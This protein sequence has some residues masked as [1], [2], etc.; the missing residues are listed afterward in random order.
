MDSTTIRLRFASQPRKQANKK[1]LATGHDVFIN[2]SCL[3]PLSLLYY[4]CINGG[5]IRRQL[6]LFAGGVHGRASGTTEQH[7]SAL[8]GPYLPYRLEG[9]PLLLG[10]VPADPRAPQGR[11]DALF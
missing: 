7:S 2:G 1:T 8:V 5:S 10:N 6:V 4:L 3:F 9:H 11:G